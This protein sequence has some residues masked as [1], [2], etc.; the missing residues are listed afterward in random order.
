[1]K[2]AILV[3]QITPSLDTTLDGYVYSING[4]FSIVAEL[5]ESQPVAEQENYDLIQLKSF[6]STFTSR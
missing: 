4:D 2:L 3:G 1:L 5:F 6:S